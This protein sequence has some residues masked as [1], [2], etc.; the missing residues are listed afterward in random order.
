MMSALRYKTKNYG[1]Y[2]IVG[3]PIDSLG[4]FLPD[5]LKMNPVDGANGDV[6]VEL[7]LPEEMEK[8]DKETLDRAYKQWRETC[9]SKEQRP[10][11]DHVSSATQM[12]QGK[13]GLFSIASQAISY[14]LEKKTPTDNAEFI[15]FLK[16]Q[17]IALL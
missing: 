6:I 8:M 2:V 12:A 17:I 11:L 10:K 16:Q 13:N 5:Y 1:E 3:F 7:A 14:P 4:K 9:P 15:S